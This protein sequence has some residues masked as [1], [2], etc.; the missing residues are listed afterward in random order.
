MSLINQALRKAQHQRTPNRAAAAVD[1]TSSPG[2]KHA[3]HS[4][5]PGLLIGLIAGI[6][7][8]IGLVIG[9]SIIV[10]RTDPASAVEQ[11][12]A[13]PT[14]TMLTETTRP[15]AKKPLFQP[16]EQSRSIATPPTASDGLDILSELDRARNEVE[17][18]ATAVE[19]A[20]SIP[21]PSQEVIDWLT[22]ATISGVRISKTNSKLILNNKTY[23]V[24]ETVNFKIGIKALIIEEKRIL[25]IDRNGVKYFKML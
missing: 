4:S 12:P 9:L 24:G 15:E 3:A 2:H 6:A 11:L 14:P 16:L 25:F 23:S 19:Q 18:K 21:K 10:L 13:R 20:E 17:A 7:V 5:R 1:Y 8:L 22:H